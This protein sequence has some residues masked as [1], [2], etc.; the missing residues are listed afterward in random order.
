MRYGLI[1]EKLGHSFSKEIHERIADYSYDLIPLSKSEFKDF[2]EQ[3]QFTA[4]NVTIPYK[5]DVIPYLDE[6]DDNAAA[7]G[8]V[9][10]I[11]NCNGRLKGFNTDYSGFDY[12]VRKHQ[13]A[14]KDHKVLVIGN[15]GA[16]A[17]IQTVVKNYSP[18]AMIIVDIVS[19]NG[20]ISYEECYAQHT[21]AQVIIN[22]SPIGMY[23]KISNAPIDLN[24]FPAVE[25]VMDVIYNPLTTKLCTQA[26]AKGIIH[27]NGLEMLIA[28]A[29]YAVEFFL[30]KTID[31]AVIDEIYR[32]ML[33]QRVNIALIGMPSCGK[34]TLAKMLADKMQRTAVE[35][36]E[37]IVQQ[38]GKSIPEIFAQQ[39]ESGFR[40]IE[41]EVTRQFSKENA[42]ILSTGGGIIKHEVNIEHLRMNSILIFIDRDLEQLVFEDANRP[43][44]SSKEAV[45]RLYEERYE[46]YCRYS[47]VIVKNND[48][49]ET[50]CEAVLNAYYDALNK[51]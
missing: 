22:T 37:M 26:K 39:G 43:L 11:V 14:L 31:D 23:P 1:G 2:M 48:T 51:M 44:S 28:Q 27:V 30:Q 5:K 10:T 7:I 34:S 9:N 50:V 32:D 13:I 6:L 25:A 35:L 40:A 20:A 49:L 24:D 38:A 45:T 3:K 19:G 47:D 29:K 17:A 15:G 8:A 16:S 42:L 18:S 41:T 33:A 46:L 36:D 12:M 4:I 21:D